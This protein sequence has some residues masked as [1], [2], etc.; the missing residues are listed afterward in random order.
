MRQRGIRTLIPAVLA[1]AIVVWEAPSLAAQI[2][3]PPAFAIEAADRAV[4]LIT[5]TYRAGGGRTARG[6]GSGIIIDPVGLILTAAHVVDRASGLEVQLQNG[7]LLPADVVGTDRVYDVALLRVDA[8]SFPLP[9]ATLGASALLQRGDTVVALGRAP[10]RQAGPTA[11]TFLEVDLEARAGVPTLLSTA[12]VY[13]GDS[14]GALVNGRGEV[15]G[16]I[17]AITRRG[18]LSLAVAADAARAVLTDLRAG[19]VRHP[20]L[21]ITGRTLTGDLATELGLTL[22]NGVLILE[23]L[24]RSPASL[25]GLRGGESNGTA[26]FPT[27]GDV[28]TAIDGHAVTTFGALAA[29]VL[30]KRVGDLVTLEINRDGHA[31]TTTVVLGERPAL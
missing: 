23:V 7:E 13:P 25:A 10:R 16:V 22:H 12:V 19:D 14:G 18:L 17:V 21:G 27:G 2:A 28:I 1:L 6:S 31:S 15:I 20:W 8:A 5:A 26:D 11:G 3:S 30:S 4:V 24:P 29:Y 9:A